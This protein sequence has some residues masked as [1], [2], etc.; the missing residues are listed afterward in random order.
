MKKDIAPPT[1]EDIAVAVIK[2]TNELNETE[3]NVYLI[4]LK[5]E[6]IEAVLVS[7]KGYGRL[8]EEDVKTSTLRHFLDVVDPKDFKKIEPIVETLFGLNNEFWVSFYINKIMYDKK[9]IFLPETIKEENFILVP[10][11]NKKGVMIK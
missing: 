7:S 5:K 4:N 10:Y 3:W 11:I 6:K 2:E 9:Y 8:N 1:V